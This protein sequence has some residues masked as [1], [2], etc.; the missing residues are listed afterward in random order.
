MTDPAHDL[1]RIYRDLGPGALAG[2]A[3]HYDG[4]DKLTVRAQ[5]YA[6]C[7]VFEDLRYGLDTG[8]ED[9]LSKSIVS[10]GWLFPP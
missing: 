9:Y 2:L 4:A 7:T 5:F 3:A 10:L 8:R 1:A 6:R